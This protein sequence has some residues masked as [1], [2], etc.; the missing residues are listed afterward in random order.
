MEPELEERLIR[1]QANR[2]R[3]LRRLE[4]F[5]LLKVRFLGVPVVTES[6]A[7]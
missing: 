6:A 3:S 7:Q 1:H 2:K 5:W 4:R